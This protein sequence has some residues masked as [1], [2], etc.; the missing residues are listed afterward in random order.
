V[1]LGG[2][3]ERARLLWL[4]ERRFRFG[5]YGGIGG[6]R[7]AIR[8]RGGKPALVNAAD[9]VRFWYWILRGNVSCRVAVRVST[10]SRP[11]PVSF[12]IGVWTHV[13]E[14]PLRESRMWA[15]RSPREI[16]RET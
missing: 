14:H 7:E 15:R 6:G 8:P 2:A 1:K 11:A 13:P 10:F 9:A 4:L 12:V 5:H 16:L 3:A